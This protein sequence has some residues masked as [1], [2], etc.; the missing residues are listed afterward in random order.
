MTTPVESGKVGSHSASS[1]TLD[2][3]NN[4]NR[5]KVNSW[6]TFFFTFQALVFLGLM[7]WAIK[8][9]W[10]PSER[11]LAKHPNSIDQFYEFNKSLAVFMIPLSLISAVPAWLLLKK[12]REQWVWTTLLVF[13]CL[14][15]FNSLIVFIPILIFW[16]KDNNKEYYGKLKNPQPIN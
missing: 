16:I 8:D 12:K 6:V 7:A 2:K 14:N 11:V 13:I 15:L 4:M 3:E 5:P 10:F 1:Q 9:G